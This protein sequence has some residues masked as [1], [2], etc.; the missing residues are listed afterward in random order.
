[1]TTSAASSPRA[2][3]PG[4]SFPRARAAVADLRV[5]V[6]SDFFFAAAMRLPSQT[7]KRGCVEYNVRVPF[8]HAKPALLAAHPSTP[9]EAVRALSARVRM[10]DPDM[11]VFDYSLDAD[12]SRVRIPLPVASAQTAGAGAQATGAGAR[13]TGAG[14]RATGAGARATAA[15]ARATGAGA[16]ATAAGAR[17]DALW[18]H[19]CFE[20][21]IAPSDLPGYHEFNFSPSRD[22]AIYRFSAYREGMAPAKIEQ[23]PQISLHRGDAGVELKATVRL[24]SLADLRGAPRLKV[25]LAAVIEDENGRLSYWALRHAPGKPDFHHPNAFALE[26]ARA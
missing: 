24:E 13:A 21:F 20:A 17:A 8:I 15:G 12:L 4:A 11:L 25:A 10:E 7:F 23:A 22:W 16:R 2:L 9:N 19:T 26:V 5:R 1:M 14:A 18:K 3:A 6:A